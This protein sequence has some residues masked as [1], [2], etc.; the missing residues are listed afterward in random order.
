MGKFSPRNDSGFSMTLF[1][2]LGLSLLDLLRMILAFFFIKFLKSVGIVQKLL[3]VMW[4]FLRKIDMVIFGY[5]YEPRIYIND[6]SIDFSLNLLITVR[7]YWRC[8]EVQDII[9]FY[10][11][12]KAIFNCLSI[13]LPRTMIREIGQKLIGSWASLFGLLFKITMSN[14]LEMHHVTRYYERN[15]MVSNFFSR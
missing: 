10:T 4:R 12:D 6:I 15:L 8:L 3:I 14:L 9:V 1:V 11:A 7:I 2:V 13:S 5:V